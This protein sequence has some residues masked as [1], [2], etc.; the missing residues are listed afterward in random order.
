[1]DRVRIFWAGDST[2][3]YNRIDTY[4]QTGIGQ[5]LGLYLKPKVQIFD[6]AE[7]GRST[8]SFIDEGR[9][10]DIEKEL[11]PG[12]FFFV[13]FGHNDEKV[14]DPLRYT[15]C[16]GGFQENLQIYIRA[17]RQRKA[18]PV[19][20]SPIERRRFDEHG[21]FMAGTHGQYP[22]AMHQTAQKE[23]VP[24]IDMTEKTGQLLA[25]EGKE[26]TAGFFMHIK[27]GEFPGTRYENGLTDDTHLRYEGAVKIAGLVAE[28]LW[29]LGGRYRELV[30]ENPELCVRQ[31]E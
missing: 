13:Q 21:N 3:K 12:D 8:K 15:K 9:L 30:L 2:V 7:N 5:V 23:Q 22:E 4:P 6:M 14:D 1:M 28:G 31:M 19:L 27:P 17:A 16:Y 10:A 24:F 18:Y 11:E 20:L 26:K 29:E 25:R